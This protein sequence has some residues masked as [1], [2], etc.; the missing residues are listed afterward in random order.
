MDCRGNTADFLRLWQH[1]G[2]ISA[3]TIAMIGAACAQLGE[4]ALVCSGWSDFSDSPISSM[5]R[6]WAR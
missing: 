5:S 6:W 1:T 2:R 4:R 3:D